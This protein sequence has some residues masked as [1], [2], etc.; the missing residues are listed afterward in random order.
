MIA[1]MRSHNVG[2][3]LPERTPM[4]AYKHGSGNEDRHKQKHL[5]NMNIEETMEKDWK[6]KPP[7]Y[8]KIERFLD[9]ALICLCP[10]GS[11]EW[12]QM[13]RCSA[14]GQLAWELGFLHLDRLI[15][16]ELRLR[17]GRL[18]GLCVAVLDD[19]HL[20]KA[21]IKKCLTRLRVF[22]FGAR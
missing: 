1:A 8:L 15:L 12:M 11:F 2:G 20:G 6:T 4:H 10:C 3:I 18:C 19:I 13:Q 16:V 22:T 5:Q 14:S 17:R 9:C 21:K 7:K